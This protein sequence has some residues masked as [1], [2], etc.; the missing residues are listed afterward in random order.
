MDRRD[1]PILP[2]DDRLLKDSNLSVCWP[3]ESRHE[4]E[5][6]TTALQGPHLA[7]NSVSV[8]P[9]DT[10]NIKTMR[11]ISIFHIDLIKIWR[12][13]SFHLIHTFP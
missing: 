12:L 11:P 2:M 3:Q 1:F 7:F 5:S 13:K 10:H 9:E 6:A 4:F 8:A